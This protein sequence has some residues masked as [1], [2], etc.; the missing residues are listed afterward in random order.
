MLL[1]F[2]TVSVWVYLLYAAATF[3]SNETID[4][5]LSQP[6]RCSVVV[7]ERSEPD[8]F[9][10]CVRK[11]TCGDYVRV[12]A[13]DYY[14]L[15]YPDK[16]DSLTCVNELDTICYDFNWVFVKQSYVINHIKTVHYG[17]L[18]MMYI[19]IAFFMYVMC[20]T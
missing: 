16:Y 10:K 15:S 5:V 3:S 9:S 20:Y 13:G 7:Q 2:V 11:I 14:G 18:T 17:L 4:I 1:R 19:A 8:R 12:Q 6:L